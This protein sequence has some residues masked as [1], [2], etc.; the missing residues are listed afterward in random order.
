MPK[1]S[2]LLNA[3]DR[4][5][6]RDYD[7]EKQQK[8]QKQAGRRK[9]RHSDQ[10][11]NSGNLHGTITGTAHGTENEFVYTDLTLGVIEAGIAGNEDGEED[12]DDDE[13]EEEEEEEEE[14]GDDPDD[15]ALSDI[16]SLASSERGDL[17]PYQRLT[18]NNTTAI[19]AAHKAIA[20]PSKL[21]FSTHQILSTD[22]PVDI[23]D[24]HDDM[25][26]ELA[27]YKQCLS[28]A[29]TGRKRLKQEGVPF[30]RPNDYFAEMVKNDEHMGKIKRKM[31]EDAGARKAS[32]E[33]KRQRDLKKFG[34]Q[35][36]VAKEQERA[37]EKRA[38]L[39]KID[40]LKRSASASPPSV[41][42]LTMQR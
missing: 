37:K 31:V 26:R 17:I 2:K 22:T 4:Q 35:V 28:G 36:Q 9:L 6:G 12:G 24:V 39:E 38:T 29:E 34:K 16:D 18:I 33:A 27:F 40:I 11:K 7:V 10:L 32:Q 20:L 25:S 14:Q 1:K 21:P 41:I 42:H 5:Q 15:I 3:L 19:L 30:S 23:A 8:F 13:E